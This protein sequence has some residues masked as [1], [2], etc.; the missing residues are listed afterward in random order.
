MEDELICIE[1][2]QPVAGLLRSPAV[3]IILQNQANYV[4]P[5]P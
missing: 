1:G 5:D 3:R 4:K 2:G